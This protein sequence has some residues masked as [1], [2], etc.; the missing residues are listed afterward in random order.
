MSSF[1]KL[2]TNQQCFKR[3]SSTLGG[4]YPELERIN[5]AV[6]Q[7]ISKMS[8]D[9]VIIFNVLPPSYSFQIGAWAIK[10]TLLIKRN[11]HEI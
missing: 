7:E 5:H 3:V 9:F 2:L 8:V 6:Q 4:V 1:E 11:D 10:R